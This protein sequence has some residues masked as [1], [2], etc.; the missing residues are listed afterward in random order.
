MQNMRKA[1]FCQKFV[2]FC[3]NFAHPET[4]KIANYKVMSLLQFYDMPAPNIILID[5]RNDLQIHLQVMTPV[6]KNQSV[7]KC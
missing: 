7:M 2:K 3:K 1:K 6:C 4:P 5:K